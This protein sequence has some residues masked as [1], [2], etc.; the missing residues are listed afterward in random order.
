MDTKFLSGGEVLKF[1]DEAWHKYFS[2]ENY[3]NLIENKFGL[4]N[5]LNIEDLSKIR[6]KRKYY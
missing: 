3:L 2:N 6:L 4:Q 1:R 5:R